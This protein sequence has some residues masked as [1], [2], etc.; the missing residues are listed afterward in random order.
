[1]AYAHADQ[2]GYDGMPRGTPNRQLRGAVRR[3]RDQHPALSTRSLESAP[4]PCSSG[5]RA[6]VCAI[7]DCQEAVKVI[8]SYKAADF[9]SWR[10]SSLSSP[11]TV[12]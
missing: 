9:E 7:E 11:L 8:A 4:A 12:V 5:P 1:M 10:P 3:L 2:G 6:V